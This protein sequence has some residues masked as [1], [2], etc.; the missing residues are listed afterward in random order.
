MGNLFDGLES[1]GFKLNQKIDIYKNE[2]SKVNKTSEEKQEET[3][4]ET[5][6]LFDKGYECPV[7]DNKFKAK[8]VRTGRVHLDGADDDLKPNYKEMNSLK[9]DAV[10]CP[11]CGYAALSSQYGV[12]MPTQRK[13]VIEKISANFKCPSLP[14]GAYTYDD[15][16]MRHKMALL[17]SV[18][19]PGKDSEKAYT[20]L[21]LAWLYRDYR[22]E[23]EVA[24]TLTDE[25]KKKMEDSE[26]EFLGNAFDGFDAAYSKESFP[27]CNMDHFTLEILIAQLAYEVGKFKESSQHVA[28]LLSSPA[29]P[30]RVKNKAI[31]LKESLKSIEN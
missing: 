18:V 17:S 1:L 5:D 20:C 2:E 11:K 10:M 16:I 15:A 19:K 28:H 25:K 22:H 8:T 29:A 27:I 23:L 6:F 13:N 3:V 4:L 30:K 9:Y 14:R 31:D 26:K 21:K 7:C 12:L 24:G